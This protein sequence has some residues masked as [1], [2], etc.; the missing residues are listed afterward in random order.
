MEQFTGLSQ[1]IVA[2]GVGEKAVVSN[3]VESLWQDVDEE[4][5]DELAGIEGHGFVA[6]SLFG[7]VIFPLEGDAVIILGDQAGVGDGDAM[8]V[9]GEVSQ[10]GLGP[11]E[12]SF[13]IFVRRP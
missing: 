6:V 9:L 11:L 12:G 13:G 7:P 3:A 10:Y 2:D 8:G 4:T 5:A 1:V